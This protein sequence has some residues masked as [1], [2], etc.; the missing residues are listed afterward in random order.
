MEEEIRTLADDIADIKA[1]VSGGM[2]NVPTPP[3]YGTPNPQDLSAPSPE[4]GNNFEEQ[5]FN[6]DDFNEP[7]ESFSQGEPMN[8]TASPP[9]TSG[10]DRDYIQELV[11]TILE[12]KWSEFVTKTGDL[13]TWK[14]RTTSDLIAT[15]QEVLRLRD[16]FER[17]QHSMIGKSKEY[18][19]TMTNVHSEMK[20]LEKVF[21]KIL[22]PLTDNIKELQRLTQDLKKK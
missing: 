10:I 1:G 8:L 13:N 15:K 11:E 16:S 19:E 4:E 12:E 3:G 20:A 5:D 7:K 14:E 9:R 21:E 18:G 2:E 22:E 17:L 6:E